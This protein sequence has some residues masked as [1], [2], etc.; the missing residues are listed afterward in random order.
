MTNS[1]DTLQNNNVVNSDTKTNN[2]RVRRVGTFTMGLSLIV[3]GIAII[4]SLFSSTFSIL[5]VAKFSPMILIFIGVEILIENF[6]NKSGKIKYDFL[7][8]F[9]CF[10]LICGS[11]ATACIPLAIKYFG[12]ERD[13][14]VY[15]LS[16]EV[17]DECYTVLKNE[18]I[19]EMN[20]NVYI[21]EYAYDE[22]MTIEDL[23]TVDAINL[24]IKLSENYMSPAIFSQKCKDI[25]NKLNA[26]GLSFHYINIQYED[27][28]SN[29]EGYQL[30]INGD[31]KF[32]MA[33]EELEKYVI[34]G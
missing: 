17:Y 6:I 5:T 16:Q 26:T 14:L 27:F 12:P 29:N 24:D 4:I 34:N 19:S 13:H 11:L 22:N 7:S 15:K 28:D 3:V 1:D 18:K 2:V 32:N 10:I 25:L 20:A 23:S 31:F 33:A 21:D 30:D 9:I 8:G